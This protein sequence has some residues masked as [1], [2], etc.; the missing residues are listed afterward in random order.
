MCVVSS[1]W[2][3]ELEIGAVWGG[4]W[5]DPEFGSVW[6][7]CHCEGEVVFRGAGS[8]SQKK[9]TICRRLLSRTIIF[10]FYN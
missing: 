7:L 8:L 10:P 4:G 5:C 6:G 3:S 9:P 2:G 1:W